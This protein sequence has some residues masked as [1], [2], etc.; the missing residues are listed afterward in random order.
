MFKYKGI[1]SFL[2]GIKLA[3]LSFSLTI[4]HFNAV[5]DKESFRPFIANLSN[6]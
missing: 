5:V 2:S 4:N 1:T 6:A 3:D